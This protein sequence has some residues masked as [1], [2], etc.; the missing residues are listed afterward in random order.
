MNTEQA[1]RSEQLERSLIDMAVES[2]RFAR[3]FS[4]LVSKLDAGEGSRY[5][6]QLRYFQKRLEDSLEAS[7]LKIVNVEGQPFDPGMA[8]SAINIGDFEPDDVLLVDQMVEPIIMG[9]EGLRKQGT[10]M[11]RKV[12]A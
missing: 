7:G 2:W 8:A 5:V 11:L 10:V 6:N 3:L 12:A 4:R 1:D 9:A